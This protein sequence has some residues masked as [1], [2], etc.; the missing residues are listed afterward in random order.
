MG[1]FSE[2]WGTLAVVL[3]GRGFC[4]RPHRLRHRPDRASFLVAGR[5]A[6]NC[7]SARVGMRRHRPGGDA[8][9]DLACHRLA[10][11]SAD[12]ARRAGWRAHRHRAPTTT[13]SGYYFV[14][15]PVTVPVLPLPMSVAVIV[16]LP[17]AVL[18]VY[19]GVTDVEV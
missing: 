5:G 4:Q 17:E 14:R 2:D 11:P 16:A 8:A 10:P 13:A 6:G 3:A 19:F 18:P 15:V 12:A 7:G 1:L 9:D